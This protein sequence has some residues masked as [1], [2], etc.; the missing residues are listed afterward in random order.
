MPRK[1]DAWMDGRG[2]LHATEFDALISD[3][4][5]MSEGEYTEALT[6]TQIAELTKNWDAFAELMARYKQ[7]VENPDNG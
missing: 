4:G 6:E 2:D 5:R 7:I 3:I 1:I